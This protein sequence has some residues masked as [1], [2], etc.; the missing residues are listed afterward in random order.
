MIRLDPALTAA[1]RQGS[2]R[3]WRRWFLRCRGQSSTLQS[4]CWPTGRTRRTPQKILIKVIT[5]LGDLGE[6]E[7][8]GAWAFRIACRHLVHTRKQGRVETQRLTFRSFAADLA[9]ALE[10]LP[11]ETARGPE[12]QVLI[13]DVKIGCT[14]AM[15]TC[16]SRPLRAAYILGEI[17]E[18]SDAEAA[19]AL[20]IDQAAFRQRLRR[21][22]A[23]VAGFVQARCGI[24]S[25]T[26]ACRCEQRV[27]QTIRL[28]RAE[29]HQP[30]LAAQDSSV[31]SVARVRESIARL[32]RGRASVALMRSNPEFTTDVGR[33][34]VH[35]LKAS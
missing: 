14:L 8:A 34:V 31:P 32:E 17:F 6:G 20:E 11:D 24:V 30:S 27:A 13:E 10:Q 19:L 15:L 25:P 28:G 16:L 35:L 21:A 4:G 18:L 9:E 1:A 3:R 29:K 7:A 5:H 2:R 33:L 23:L 26:A 12:T 22:R